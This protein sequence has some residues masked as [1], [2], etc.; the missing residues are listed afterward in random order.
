V[1]HCRSSLSCRLFLCSDPYRVH[2]CDMCGLIAKANLK[3]GELMC[4]S[5]KEK[6][7]ISQA[8]ARDPTH[9]SGEE[10]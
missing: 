7:K 4:L 1:P 6:N 2:V 8:S 10:G 3:S 9:F 5:C